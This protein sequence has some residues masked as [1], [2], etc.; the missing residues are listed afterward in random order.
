VL[1]K[2]VKEYLEIPG[3]SRTSR[4]ESFLISWIEH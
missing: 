1:A 4:E 2:L 3:R